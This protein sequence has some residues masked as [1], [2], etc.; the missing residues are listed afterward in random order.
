MSTRDFLAFWLFAMGVL[1]V[2]ALFAMFVA[3]IM[4]LVLS[5]IGVPADLASG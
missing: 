4:C 3:F 5:A 2:K 1:L